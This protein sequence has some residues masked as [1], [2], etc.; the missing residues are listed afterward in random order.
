MEQN[1]K[2]KTT[3]GKP[4]E[5]SDQGSLGL[6]ALGY[7]GLRLWREKRKETQGKTNKSEDSNN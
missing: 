7:I 4:H 1:Y 6:L 2:L 3:D 5:V